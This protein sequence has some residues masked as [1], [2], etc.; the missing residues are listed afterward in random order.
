MYVCFQALKNGWRA[1]LRPFIG[2]DG[3]FLK[4]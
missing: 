3:T 2:L 1:S 4:G